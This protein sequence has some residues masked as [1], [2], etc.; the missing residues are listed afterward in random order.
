[1][2]VALLADVHGNLPALEA[3]LAEA[4]HEN[5]DGCW[6][7]GDLVGYGPFP[8]ETVCR[9]RAE[10]VVSIRGNYDRKVLA[11]PR[12]QRSW[13]K[14]KAP[15]KYFAFRWAY[16]QLSVSSRDYLANLPA[17]RSIRAGGLR[18]L[19]THGSPTADDEALAPDTPPSRLAQLARL[20]KVDVIACG[21][22][23]FPFLAEA[24]GTQFVNP[25][26]VGRPEGNDPRASWAL[27]ELNA[28]NMAIQLRRTPYNIARVIREVHR[29]GLPGEFAQ[30]FR[31][32]KNLA[33]VYDEGSSS[34][35]ANPP[36]KRLIT[37]H[38]AP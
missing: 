7:L 12:K 3:V 32:G 5:V 13:R 4:R 16:E 26:S 34:S 20:A 9:L 30:M 29:R 2:R 11:F 24:A 1:M 37:R 22:S 31:L 27:M 33:A 8:E 28:G 10:G 21:H 6:N 38:P 36:A 14:R 23:H 25:G 18:L 19:L 17:Q 35:D 15:Q